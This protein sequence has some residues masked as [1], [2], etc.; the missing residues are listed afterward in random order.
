[1]FSSRPPPLARSRPPLA[2]ASVVELPRLP[3]RDR[4]EVASLIPFASHVL[5]ECDS[6]AQVRCSLPADAAAA[7][8]CRGRDRQLRILRTTFNVVSRETT[9]NQNCQIIFSSTVS[10]SS[11]FIARVQVFCSRGPQWRQRRRC[12]QTTAARCNT[13]HGCCLRSCPGPSQRRRS[14]M[15]RRSSIAR[16]IAGGSVSPRSLERDPWRT[17]RC[18]RGS[19]RRTQQRAQ[20]NGKQRSEDGRFETRAGHQLP[21]E[22]HL[23][24]VRGRPHRLA[25]DS[26]RRKGLVECVLGR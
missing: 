25:V 19:G 6:C 21:D 2:R 5:T 14:S 26:S 11:L 20:C 16:V 17:S 15:R 4:A 23:V 22:R 7:T 12:W 18:W 24:A 13:V 10:S 1:M 8:S 9:L 3:S